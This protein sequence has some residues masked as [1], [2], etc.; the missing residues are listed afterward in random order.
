MHTDAP[1]SSS[2]K[3]SGPGPRLPLWLVT[4]G[5]GVIAGLLS[6]LGG[7]ATG[8]AIP[9]RVE[10]PPEYARMSG[11]E[12][13]AANAMAMGKAVRSVEQKRAAAAFGLLGL[14]L[15]AALGLV[16]DLPGGG[17]SPGGRAAL[18]GGL[19][20]AGAGAGLAYLSVPVFFRYLN[21][22][23]GLVEL[24]LTHSVIFG[25][26]GAAAGVGLGLGLADTQAL[27]RTILGGLL[28]GLL[29]ALALETTISLAFPLMRTYQPVSAELAPRVLGHLCVALCIA[30]VAGLAA[31]RR[32]DKPVQKLAE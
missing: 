15:G 8:R 12:K 19:A 29:G 24:F 25:G 14:F 27:G 17:A 7:E 30:V 28:G 23:S 22:E 16:G 21:P 13:Q 18:I 11:Y 31:G 26:L 32:F 6:A 4:A 2:A 9:L 20:G 10:Y 3:E 1:P 5:A